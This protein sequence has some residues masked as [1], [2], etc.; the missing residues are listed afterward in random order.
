MVKLKTE[1]DAIRLTVE[2]SGQGID[3]EK[4]KKLFQPFMHGYASQGG[5][6]IGLYTAYKMA[7]THKGMLTYSRS[8]AL[9][10]AMFTLMLPADTDVYALEDYRNSTVTDKSETVYNKQAEQIIMEMLPQAL[11]DYRIA[12]IEDDPDMLE[13]IKEEVA[14][15]FHVD[16]YSTGNDGY[17]GLLNSKPALLIC[18]VMLPDMSGY[19]IVKKMRKHD[20]LKDIPVIMLTALGD[21]QHQIRGY[22][23]GADDYMVKPCNYRILIARAIQLIKWSSRHDALVNRVA[24]A[25][26]VTTARVETPAALPTSEKP[27]IT[28]SAD[29]HLLERIN[30]LVAQNISNPDFNIDL[31]ADIMHM[32]RTKLY[33][34]VRELTGLSPNKLLMAERMRMA[35]EL[36]E[37]SD[38]NI[39]E[40]GY[41]VGILDASYFNKCFKQHFGTSPSKYRKER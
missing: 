39:S 23:A 12:I 18:D 10:G 21:E 38:L 26:D 7:L 16:A 41:K 32:G 13:Q 31:M 8:E 22:E 30:T 4:Q 5:M 19:D 2:D 34:K 6:G 17:E 3:T 29:K 33:G 1:E 25:T 11:N 9:G 20:A 37:R 15:Y 27:L 40:I 14:V 35:A 28:S 36:L 24:E